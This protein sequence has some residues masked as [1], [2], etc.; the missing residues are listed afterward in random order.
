MLK[1]VSI[2]EKE[3][4]CLIKLEKLNIKNET[5][6]DDFPCNFYLEQAKAYL[7]QLMLTMET[8]AVLYKRQLNLP[9]FDEENV[10][11]FNELGIE[12]IKNIETYL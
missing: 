11:N 4:A 5:F 3:S 6:L 10:K 8:K 2:T 1:L 7:N 9:V 12:L